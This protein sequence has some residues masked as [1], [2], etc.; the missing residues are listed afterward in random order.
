[1]RG[2][3]QRISESGGGEGLVVVVTVIAIGGVDSSE[4]AP[5]RSSSSRHQVPVVRYAPGG[6]DLSSGREK[7]FA[8]N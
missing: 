7:K 4:E 8:D 1:M 3:R 5:S 6:R 2:Q